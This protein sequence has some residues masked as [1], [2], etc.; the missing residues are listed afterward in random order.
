MSARDDKIL[1]PR[2]V[3]TVPQPFIRSR[4]TRVE[5]LRPA[6]AVLSLPNQIHDLL[7][8]A[9]IHGDIEP[10]SRLLA[11][12]IALEFGVSRIP[13][14]EALSSLHQAGWVHIRPRYGAY[15][16]Q[17]SLREL[18]HLFEARAGLEAE[19]AG[20][21][22]SRRT[23]DDIETLRRVVKRSVSAADADDVEAAF[24]ASVDFNVA[25]RVS[26]QNDVL[27]AISLALE[28]RAR[29][30]F[31]PIAKTLAGDWAQRQKILVDIIESGDSALASECAR[32]HMMGTGEDVIRFLDLDSDN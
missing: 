24:H 19:I 16:S 11:D 30:Y 27:A 3:A 17:R 29:F 9:I 6:V 32:D 22:A 7:E 10:G 1:A 4:S 12:D 25:V 5:S 31:Y 8:D 26:A 13:V 20:L 18:T 28:K 2:S 23:P 14:R 21:A 15:V